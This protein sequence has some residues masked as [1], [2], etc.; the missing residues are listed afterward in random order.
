MATVTMAMVVIQDITAM[1][2]QAM[3][4]MAAMAAMVMVMAAIH[5][6]KNFVD[7]I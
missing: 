4:D 5:T 6:G 2:I 7:F 3:A 1:V